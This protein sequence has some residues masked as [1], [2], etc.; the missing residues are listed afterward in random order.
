MSSHQAQASTADST[1][2]Q[3]SW[4]IYLRLLNQA[5]A[6]RWVMVLA[7]F[8]M[9][10]DALAQSTFIYLLKPLVDDAFTQR[11]SSVAEWLPLAIFGLILLRTVGHF[12]GVY[13]VEWTGRRLIADLRQRLFSH[14]LHLPLRFFQDHSSGNLISRITYNTEQV[15]QA[16]TNGTVTLVRDTLTTIGLFTVMFI[17]SPL[18]TVA[19]LIMAPVV[20]IVVR[21]VSRRFRH[22][23]HQ[24]Q[25][26][27]GDVTQVAEEAVNGYQVVKIYGGEALENQR[28]AQANEGS[29]KLQ[30]RLTANRLSSSTVIQ[31][32]AGLALMAILWLATQ[33]P[34]A[35]TI[36]AGVFMSV[37]SAMMAVIAPLKRLATV[38]A[39]LQKGV[40]AAESIYDILDLPTEDSGGKHRT[41]RS[42]GDI[43]IE[44]V[45]FHYANHASEGTD[46]HEPTAVL[47]DVS[48]HLKP[49]T[50][51]ALVGR[52]GS[53]KSTLAA[54]L[55]RFYDPQQGQILLDGVDIREWNRESLREQM[56]YVG[57][58]V[59][60]F[61]DSIHNNI[62]YGQARTLN[63][64]MIHA[65]A[66]AAHVLEFTQRLPEQLATKVGDRGHRL[67]GGERQ[68]LAIAR[69]LLKQAPILI[70]DEATS[71]LDNESEK[72][73]QDALQNLMHEQTTL[74]IAHRLSTV[75]QA[76]QILVMDQ[77]RIVQA[78]RHDALL[79]E[80]GLYADLYHR[81]FNEASG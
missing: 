78:G 16:A 71:A 13:S 37:L 25:D 46:A 36:S 34:W 21:V 8:G 58:E 55:T 17:Q 76:D 49:G 69:A 23:S 5:K 53:G 63:D 81:R 80:G 10:A 40:A 79:A 30:L 48:I 27:M 35:S 2:R 54:L 62:A 20:A 44:Q 38:H 33:S 50:V 66:K 59:M 56:A 41:P 1:I 52:S 32:C 12:T 6:Y 18:L 77:G 72:L 67:S 43:R 60:L 28:F 3:A 22:L 75:E 15:A 24:I 39:V 64:E 51:T 68:R 42:Q 70:L 9:L 26:T 73:I 29:R 57:Q 4:R 47:H 31:W 61:N 65:A 45:S 74:V 19:L 14:Y 7:V 11:Q